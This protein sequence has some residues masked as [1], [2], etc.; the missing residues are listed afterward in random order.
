MIKAA[1]RHAEDGGPMPPELDRY[2]KW[3]A[4]GVLP[5]AGGQLDQRAGEL[6]RMLAAAN[7]HDLWRAHK[8]GELKLKDM[9]KEQLKAL[10]GLKDLM[11]G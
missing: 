1:V 11:D 8:K 5:L 9:N 4:W 2:F 3:K 7:A 10:K 6:D